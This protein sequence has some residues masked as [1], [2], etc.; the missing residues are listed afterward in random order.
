MVLG[1]QC[2]KQE[3][4]RR[5]EGRLTDSVPSR[6]TPWSWFGQRADAE[7]AASIM[8]D[9]YGRDQHENE[10]VEGKEGKEER[11]EGKSREG[12]CW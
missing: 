9:I 1:G 5:M 7:A 3:E 8:S 12:R 11:R 2:E 10:R 4:G 6:V